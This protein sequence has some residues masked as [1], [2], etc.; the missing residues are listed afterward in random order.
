MS[1]KNSFGTIGNRTLDL[2]AC[3][4]VP[5][6]TSSLRAPSHS[7]NFQY[8]YS[9]PWF[10]WGVIALCFNTNDATST[11]HSIWMKI[12][13]YGKI[14]SLFTA[15][16]ETKCNT[17]ASTLTPKRARTT[18][19]ERRLPGRETKCHESLSNNTPV[20]GNLRPRQHTVVLFHVLFK[21]KWICPFPFSMLY[22]PWAVWHVSA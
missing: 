10:L 22:T 2:P 21:W 3:S 4:A 7:V 16:M 15:F 17:Q 13:N 1:M 5:Q 12:I 9:E 11:G 20:L 18:D 14:P 19:H 8:Y 6:A